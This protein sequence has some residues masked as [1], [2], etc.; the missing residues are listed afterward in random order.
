M[1]PTRNRGLLVAIWFGSFIVAL[2]IVGELW[3]TGELHDDVYVGALKLLSTMYA[4]YLAA[5]GLF[6][7]GRRRESRAPKNDG[8][9]AALAI[10]SSTVWNGLVLLPLVPP[11]LH[12]GDIASALDAVSVVGS[13]LSWLVAGAI[14]YYFVAAREGHAN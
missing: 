5:I 8:V 6:F 1:S 12:R 10:A 7:W 4:P 14:A 3:V 2:G 13:T 11:L 9:R